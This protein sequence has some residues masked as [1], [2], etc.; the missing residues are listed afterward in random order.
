MSIQRFVHEYFG[1]GDDAGG[2]MNACDEGEWCKWDD[3]SAELMKLDGER[4]ALRIAIAKDLDA[5]F[6]RETAELRGRLEELAEARAEA[7]Q[8]RNDFYGELV[9][10]RERVTKAELVAGA[11]GG[12]TA[13]AIV[14]ALHG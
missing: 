5:Q 4:T 13:S 10:L 6:Q 9:K 3:V 11:L 12:A 1:P 8:Q 14:R 7:L 2:N